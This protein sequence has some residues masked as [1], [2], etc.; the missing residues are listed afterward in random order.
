MISW[1][2]PSNR[3]SRLTLPVG[4]S[5]SYAFSTAIHGIRRRSAAS[6]SRARVRAFSFSSIC[7]RADS[8]AS[9]ATIGGVRMAGCLP[10]WSFSG[11][12][13][14]LIVVSEWDEVARSG[15]TRRLLGDCG[16]SLSWAFDRCELQMWRDSGPLVP[17]GEKGE[18]YAHAA[19]RARPETPQA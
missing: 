1:L 13:V 15:C 16:T 2:R 17:N 5:N 8:H 12:L 9:R 7:S 19:R 10:F 4:P 3:S 11:V 14:V 6:A 18:A